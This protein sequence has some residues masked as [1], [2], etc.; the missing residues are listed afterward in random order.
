MFIINDS[1]NPDLYE[2][3]D[4][5]K[6]LDL[7]AKTAD[8]YAGVAIPFPRELLIPRHE[9][10]ARIKEMTELKTRLKDLAAYYNLPCKDQARTN[11]C[12]CN[13]PTYA[14]ELTLLKQNQK[15]TIL[16]A[17]SVGG[18]IKN[19]RNVGGWGKEALEFISE[20]GIVPQDLWPE[21][22]IQSIYH[23]EANRQIAK[24][25]AVPEWM[26]L[27]AGNR[28]QLISLLLRGIPV[29]VGFNW[30]RHQVTAENAVWLD[31][32]AWPEIRNSWGM[33]WGE[34][35]GYG[36]LQGY[37][38]DADDATAPNTVVAAG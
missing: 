13:A 31:G 14:T 26:E 34:D 22:A 16:S 37:K 18:P 17:A 4:H 36:V 30:W 19:F 20:K 2:D 35:G 32:D 27:E 33:G 29:S 3:P 6:G 5:E 25:Y 15:K 9:W 24:N 10:Q 11:Y 7:S 21:N 38:A 23:T 28:D 1:T 12:W 8:G